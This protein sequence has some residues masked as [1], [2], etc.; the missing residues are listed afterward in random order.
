MAK[1]KDTSKTT[2]PQQQGQQQRVLSWYHFPSIYGAWFRLEQLVLFAKQKLEVCEMITYFTR[3]RSE[4]MLNI[5]GNRHQRPWEPVLLH[6]D[7][8]LYFNCWVYSTCWSR[9][10]ASRD[11]RSQCGGH[12]SCIYF[13]LHV[14]CLETEILSQLALRNIL[15]SQT[16]KLKKT[17]GKWRLPK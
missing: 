14:V 3:N 2:G 12:K 15:T 9:T 17:I 7:F 13:Q 10:M 4:I 11:S 6:W 8:N 16:I 5:T 1:W